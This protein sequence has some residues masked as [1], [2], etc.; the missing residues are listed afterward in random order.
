M[1][2]REKKNENQFTISLDG[3]MLAIVRVRTDTRGPYYNNLRTVY[4]TKE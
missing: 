4:N 1:K 2:K 3:G